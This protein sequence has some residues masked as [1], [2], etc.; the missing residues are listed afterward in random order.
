MKKN[1]LICPIS[2]STNFEELFRIKK[3]PIFMGVVDKSYKAE[4]EDLVFNICQDTG[5]VQI[6]PR[7]P[8]KKLYFKSHG[9]GKIGKT[10]ADHHK[11]FHDVIQQYLSGTVVEV[12]GGHN[13]IHSLPLKIIFWEKI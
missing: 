3:F 7:I 9:S 10:W 5:S 13:S 2:K 4:Y 12:G 6:F 11:K 1:K 8:L